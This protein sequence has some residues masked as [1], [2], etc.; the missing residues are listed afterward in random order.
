MGS[1]VLAEKL[2]QCTD[3]ENYETKVNW[4]ETSLVVQWLR[5]H[6]SSAGGVG[7]IPGQRTKIPHG[8][9]NQKKKKKESV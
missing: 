6:T 4:V 3:S 1:T 8:C 5:L 9:G 2:S 7:L